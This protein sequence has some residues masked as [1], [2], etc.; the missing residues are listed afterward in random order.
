M[1]GTI[2]NRISVWLPHGDERRQ[3]YARFRACDMGWRFKP[4]S[5]KGCGF[6]GVLR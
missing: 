5:R 3:Q 6:F 2:R 4:A 1:I